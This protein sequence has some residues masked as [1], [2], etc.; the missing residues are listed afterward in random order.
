M[1]VIFE[2]NGSRFIG[3]AQAGDLLTE[4]AEA[5]GV[6]LNV[7][8]AGAGSCGGCAVELV[9]GRFVDLAG[10]L[11]TADPSGGHVLACQTQLGECAAAHVR[12][13][14]HSR[15]SGGE[16]VVVDFE[17]LGAWTHEPTVRKECLE[18]ERPTLADQAPDIERIAHALA[19]RGYAK[20]EPALS[21]LRDAPPACRAGQYE[22]TV[23]LARLGEEGPWRMTRV[24][25]GDTAE[26]LY[27]LAVD[28]GTTTV[29]CALVDL[30]AGRI[31]DAASSYNQQIRR[32]DNVASRIS[33]AGSGERL[34]EMQRLVI[35]ETVNPLVRLLQSRHGLSR[36]DIAAMAVACNNVMAHLLLGVDPTSLGAI[37]FQPADNAPPA[38]AAGLLGVDI[39]PAAPV[40]IAPAASAYIGGDAV[41]DLHV[42]GLAAAEGLTLVVD[43]GTNAE[44]AVGDRHGIIACSAP[45][46]PAF[47]GAGLSCGMRAATG[48]VEAVRIRPDDFSCEYAVIGGGAPSGICGSGLIDFL[49]QGRRTGLLTAAGRF[50]DRARNE[51]K[52]LQTVRRGDGAEVLAYVLAPA[53]QTDD[54]LAPLAISESDVA[55]LLQAKA[56][57]FAGVQI[58]LKQAGRSFDDLAQVFLAGGFAKHIDLDSA[59][60]MGLLPDIG[61]DRYRFVGNTSLAGAML[62][63]LDASAGPAMREL[64]RRPK[65]IELNL[66]PDFQDAYIMAMMLPHG[67]PSLFPSA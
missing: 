36:D 14:R 51:C 38:L 32:C 50:S 67:D 40:A 30:R 31:V 23:T 11:V 41:S 25:P 39:A 3:E 43:I 21:A 37:P 53:D 49:A 26:R 55:T 62:L 47:E 58:A 5:A 18:L 35:D 2:C 33:Y 6:V 27:G 52:A 16:K 59:V 28:I 42:C 48:A 65:V 17:H 8:C 57:I 46:G 60:T 20:V 9:E 4:V 15:V 56:V 22:V 54:K 61:R 7:A 34:R 44:I 10:R 1:Q 63:L 12:V 64:A 19:L 24:E 45:A 66:D 13:P 29:V